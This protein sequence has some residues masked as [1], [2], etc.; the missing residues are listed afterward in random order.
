HDIALD[1][2][3]DKMYW[4]AGG[5]GG[6]GHK[7]QRANLDGSNVENLVTRTQ[8]LFNPLGIALDVAGGKIYWTTSSKVQRANL[9]GSNVENL[10]TGLRDPGGIALNLSEL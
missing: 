6:R 7:I 1:V 3:G 2:A 5:G 9:D 4:T 8:E 10:V